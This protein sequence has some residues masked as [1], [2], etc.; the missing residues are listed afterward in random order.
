MKLEDRIQGCAVCDG[1]GKCKECATVLFS[2]FELS[3][4]GKKCNPKQGMLW[5]V[6]YCIIGI[7]ALL[8]AAYLLTMTFRP[9]VNE[10]TLDTA[11]KHRNQ[12]RPLQNDNSSYPLFFTNVHSTEISGVGVML[13][14]NWVRFV[15][16]VAV[17]IMIL[18][19]TVYFTSGI[20]TNTG[21]HER[22]S[23]GDCGDALAGGISG[24][25]Q[26]NAAEDHHDRSMGKYDDFNMRMFFSTLAAAIVCPCFALWY[27][28]SQSK[29]AHELRCADHK[30]HLFAVY[31]A[32]LAPEETNSAPIV[33]YFETYLGQKLGPP[34]TPG[35]NH[36]VG[37]SICYDY[38]KEQDVVDE[39]IEAWVVQED[40]MHLSHRA[41][42]DIDPGPTTISERRKKVTYAMKGADPL[43]FF[44][45]PS[46]GSLESEDECLERVKD[47][48]S[49]I[50]P[51]LESMTC[52]G[53]AYVVF[54]TT[55]GVEEILKSDVE[56]EP[57]TYTYHGQKL[58]VRAV[59]IEAPSVIWSSHTRDSVV[60]DVVVG[61]VLLVATIV[62]WV[63]LYLPYALDYIAYTSVPG[64]SPNFFEDLLLGLLI[65]VGNVIVANVIELVVPWWRLKGKDRRDVAVLSLGFLA[66]LMNT[67]CDLWLVMEIAKGTEINDAFSGEDTGY[68]RVLAAEL[69][70]LI[71]PGYLIL[72]YLLTP[73]FE[74]VLPYICVHSV[75]RTRT[76]ARRNAELG[77]E[78][79]PFDI[80]WRYSDICNNFTFCTTMLCFVTPNAW[81][82]FCFLVGFVILIYIIDYLKMVRF[83]S[84][85]YYTTH[86][87]SDTFSTWFAIPMTALCTVAVWWGMKCNY[88]PH[89]YGILLLIPTIFLATYIMILVYLLKKGK[90]L[91]IS[92][93]SYHE[94]VLEMAEHGK[95][96]DY[97][98]CNP[99][100][101]LRKKWLGVDEACG[102]Q[103]IVPYVS[104]KYYLQHDFPHSE[105]FGDDEQ[106][107]EGK[108]KD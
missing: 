5:P 13:Y 18:V 27:S 59:Q 51:V 1:V 102:R 89:N 34:T 6:V 81:K 108:G 4:D 67:V 53:E 66:T 65:A 35:H 12:C 19:C 101:C 8:I 9:T 43:L 10:G 75:V 45:A 41:S 76:V 31:V 70:V 54:S 46:G 90:D 58:S 17:G 92:K 3:E 36:V 20:A 33:E 84:Q 100:F 60:H 32:G 26:S 16:C 87:L 50:T 14:F 11:M 103:R 47:I 79:P 64:R 106:G 40:R 23:D 85:T 82:V 15:F 28:W 97:F 95:T 88:L 91:H 30:P 74:H 25:K 99:I 38:F 7:V 71:V 29:W 104:G 22:H 73:F 52:S 39:A 57:P 105:P 63:S 86:R 44:L 98:N 21:H 72:P 93:A 96:F 48:G 94:T 2:G 77:L 80:C 107:I 62:I 49:R 61:I 37:V 56:G 83:T 78:P 69:M 68:D 42:T 24:Q 55:A